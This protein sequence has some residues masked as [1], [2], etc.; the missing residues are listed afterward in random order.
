MR[1]TITDPK[2]QQWGAQPLEGP[3]EAQDARNHS[4]IP[5]LQTTF[6]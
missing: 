3:R 4:D 6:R 5:C 2:P 1:L